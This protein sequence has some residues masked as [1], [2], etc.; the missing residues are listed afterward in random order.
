MVGERGTMMRGEPTVDV[1]NIV[2]VPVPV[3]VPARSPGSDT[4][5]SCL[6]YG[7]GL[8]RQVP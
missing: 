6:N 7:E 8:S 4:D 2:P 3:S 5:T 1:A